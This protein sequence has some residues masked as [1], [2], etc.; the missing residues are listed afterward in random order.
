VS[1]AIVAAS[2]AP[3]SAA[4]SAASTRIFG[5]PVRDC[6]APWTQETYDEV[7]LCNS[8]WFKR[9][10]RIVLAMSCDSSLYQPPFSNWMAG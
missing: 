8:F 9:P 10:S 7:P 6:T 4:R 1:S 5:G 2:L 3:L